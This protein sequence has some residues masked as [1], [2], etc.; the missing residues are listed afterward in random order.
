VAGLNSLLERIV[1]AAPRNPTPVR[2]ADNPSEQ[3]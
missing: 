2:V 1:S 3:V